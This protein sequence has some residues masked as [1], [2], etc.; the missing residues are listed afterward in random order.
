MPQQWLRKYRAFMAFSKIRSFSKLLFR[1]TGN[2][3]E[4]PPFLAGT[5]KPDSL[6]AERDTVKI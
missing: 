3:L 5:Y 2:R 6:Q 4:S 1:W